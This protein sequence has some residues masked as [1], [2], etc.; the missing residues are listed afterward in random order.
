MTD[1]IP[2]SEDELRRLY[3]RQTKTIDEIA[4]RYDR[5]YA[6]VYEWFEKYDIKTRRRGKRGKLENKVRRIE[7]IKTYMPCSRCG[8]DVP[9]VAMDFHH[10][11]DDE[12]YM[13]VAGMKTC[14]WER[15]KN[16]IKKCE[17]LCAN[18]HR[19]VTENER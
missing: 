16:E 13:N 18:C 8:I 1:G 3:H 2:A 9:P 5:S 10:I 14:S 12:K 11:T 6:T 15:I 7:A 19:I 17:L 4:D